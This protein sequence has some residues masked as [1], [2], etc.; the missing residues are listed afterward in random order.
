LRHIPGLY[1][2]ETDLGRSVFSAETVSE[3]DII[4]SCPI[5][6]IPELEKNLIHESVLHD[7]YFV[8]PN[9][10]IVIA[11]GYG[12]LYNHSSHPNAEVIFDLDEEE[13]VIRAIREI[14]PGD[15]IFIDYADGDRKHE[16]WF[17]EK[18]PNQ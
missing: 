2:A 3:D 9:G 8:W 11:L 1:I 4:E 5:I 7:Y 16:L 14:E 6:L 13:I 12:S 18:G 17:N 15:E 10:G